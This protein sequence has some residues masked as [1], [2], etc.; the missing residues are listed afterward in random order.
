MIYNATHKVYRTYTRW[1]ERIDLR[2]MWKNAPSVLD[3]VEMIALSLFFMY[4]VTPLALLYKRQGY[5]EEELPS[6]PTR[7]VL[8][9]QE[10]RDM[11]DH[12]ESTGNRTAGPGRVFVC[13]ACGKRSYDRYGDQSTDIGWD[14]SCM[15]HAVECLESSIVIGDHG[16]VIKAEV[17]KE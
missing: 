14:A 10:V 16:R 2:L 17:W 4:A 5:S 8:S 15:M 1:S 3:W 11:C 6:Y 9:A 7:L 13:T 12:Y